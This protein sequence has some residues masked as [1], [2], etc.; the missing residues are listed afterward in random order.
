MPPPYATRRYRGYSLVQWNKGGAWSIWARDG[1]ELTT[2]L[3]L[4]G[5]RDTVDEWLNAR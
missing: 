4:D 2:G 3:T 1:E 5:A